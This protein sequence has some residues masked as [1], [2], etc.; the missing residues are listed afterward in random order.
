VGKRTVGRGSEISHLPLSLRSNAAN[1]SSL[2]DSPPTERCPPLRNDHVYTG[3]CPMCEKRVLLYDVEEA[4]GRLLGIR[5]ECW[6][7]DRTRVDV[8]VSVGR[9]VRDTERCNRPVRVAG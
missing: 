4:N 1:S 6:A 9:D 7:F 2:L 5:A 8:Q 3:V